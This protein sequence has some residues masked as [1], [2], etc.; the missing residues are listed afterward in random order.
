MSNTFFGI[1]K[2]L[3]LPYEL[4]ISL[5]CR[6]NTIRQGKNGNQSGKSSRVNSIDIILGNFHR[7]AL[8]GINCISTFLSKYKMFVT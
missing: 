8:Q 5:L 1:S 2:K 3:F 6:I 4:K 7:N